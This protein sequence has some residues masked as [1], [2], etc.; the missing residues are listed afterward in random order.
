MTEQLFAI[1][2]E[3]FADFARLEGLSSFPTNLTSVHTIDCI[4]HYEPIN[5]TSI[6]EKMN[7]SKASITKIST[8]LLEEGY[9]K[10]SQMNDNK[11]EV[12][13]SLTPKGRQIFEV[14][15]R[16]HVII[17]NRFIDS[18]NDFSESELQAVLKFFQM[19]IQHKEKIANGEGEHG[20]REGE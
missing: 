19:I 5:N 11:K 20:K 18:M 12:Y 6:A 2:S 13:F 7:L 17:E 15:A 14:H 16:M 9:I 1:E 3:E 4:G 8:K 10:R